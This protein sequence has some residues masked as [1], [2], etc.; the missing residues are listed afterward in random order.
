MQGGPPNA[1][2]PSGLHVQPMTP[3]QQPR[4]MQMG[5]PQQQQQQQQQGQSGQMPH[6]PKRGSTSPGEE[7]LS[8]LVLE[9]FPQTSLT[10]Y[11]TA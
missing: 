3:Q 6:R 10:Y 4:A 9:L 5:H 11:H 7:V 8:Q 2:G 1:G